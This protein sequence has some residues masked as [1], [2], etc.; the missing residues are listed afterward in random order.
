[1]KLQFEDNREGTQKRRKKTEIPS[2]LTK[3]KVR[4]QKLLPQK[5]SAAMFADT[6]FTQ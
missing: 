5:A 2:S 3:K 4:F 1:M 6:S